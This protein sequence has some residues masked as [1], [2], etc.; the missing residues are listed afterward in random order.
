MTLALNFNDTVSIYA[1]RRNGYGK[2]VPQTA[3]E[4]PAIYEQ[5][6]GR[7][8]AGHQDSSSSAGRL[9]LP[10]DNSFVAANGQRLEGMIA[11]INVFGYEDSQQYFRISS[12][13]PYRDT[14][15]G[16]TIQ[17]VECGLEKVENFNVGAIS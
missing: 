12:V 1:V 2:L 16:N 3:V 13:Q 11:E 4:I 15:L 14:L 6:T 10:G 9:F 8:H 5:N 7:N 17:H